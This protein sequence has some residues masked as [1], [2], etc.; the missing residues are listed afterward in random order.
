MRSEQAV[1]DV[2]A[3][4]SVPA[5]L[6]AAC[7]L[8][9]LARKHDQPLQVCVIDKGSEIGA[10]IISGALLETRAL[11]E[12][13]PDWSSRQ[14]P[15]RCAVGDDHFYMLSPE[16]ARRLP[17]WLLPGSLHNDGNYIISLGN[18]CRWLAHRRAGRRDLQ[19]FQCR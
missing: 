10:H 13:F 15:V 6:S 12:L 2:M 5:G 8:M 11:D 19:R 4:A 7:R 14:A 18:L 16:R 1:A 3:F 17:P 9:Q